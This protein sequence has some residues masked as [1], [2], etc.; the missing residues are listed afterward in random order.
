M[1]SD[2]VAH[3]VEVHHAVVATVEE[4]GV[5]AVAVADGGNAGD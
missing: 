5:V 4:G 3:F 1:E 2:A